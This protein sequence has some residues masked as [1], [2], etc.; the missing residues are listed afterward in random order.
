M[1]QT[2]LL[3]RILCPGGVS[4]LCHL[5]MLPCTHIFRGRPCKYGRL[6]RAWTWLNAEY[7]RNHRTARSRLQWLLLHYLN[8]FGA[9][10]FAT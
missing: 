3:T 5:L 9:I 7:S 8:L 1:V 6:L 4:V 2:V 10:A